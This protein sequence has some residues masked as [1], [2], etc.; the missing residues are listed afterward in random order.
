MD[1]TSSRRTAVPGHERAVFRRPNRVSIVNPKRP[2]QP[3]HRRWSGRPGHCLP[4]P[5]S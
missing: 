1:P 4:G 3:L 5:A 2:R